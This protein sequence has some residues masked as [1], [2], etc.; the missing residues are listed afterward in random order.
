VPQPPTFNVTVAVQ[1]SASSSLDAPPSS[2]QYHSLPKVFPPAPAINYRT[3]ISSQPYDNAS[4]GSWAGR[5]LSFPLLATIRPNASSIPHHRSCMCCTFLAV[6]SWPW[7]APSTTAARGLHRTSAGERA[8]VR[9]LLAFSVFIW[10]LFCSS[11]S[12][13]GWAC[14]SSSSGRGLLTSPI[15]APERD[16]SIDGRNRH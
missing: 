15:G 9:H 6:P 12:F 3:P 16:Q 4:S 8:I 5:G 2:G 14:A 1:V 10:L 11:L 13:C 7:A